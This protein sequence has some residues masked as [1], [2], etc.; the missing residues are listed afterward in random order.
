ME[1][2]PW[3][4]TVTPHRKRKHVKAAMEENGVAA[5][6]PGSGDRPASGTRLLACLIALLLLRP[7]PAAHAETSISIV[8][9]NRSLAPAQTD[10][11]AGFVE[12]LSPSGGIRVRVTTTASAGLILY[13]SC[14]TAS[15][16]IA[17][18][19]LLIKCPTAGSLITAY[20]GITALDQALWST[21][22]PVSNQDVDTDIKVIGLW[23]YSDA[24][25]A[26]STSYT[27]TLIYTVV[28]Q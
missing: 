3:S 1:P 7:V 27:N 10:Y 28:E 5:G 8:T 24:G 16:P 17:L 9:N 12:S 2:D 19:D 23:D 25:A 15:P 13:V 21:S 11:E 4:A 14:S 26:G 20:T 22:V 6:P 18:S